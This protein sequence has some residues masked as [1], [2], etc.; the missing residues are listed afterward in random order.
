MS[1]LSNLLSNLCQDVFKLK[2]DDTSEIHKFMEALADSMESFYDQINSFLLLSTEY[3]SSGTYLDMIARG[4]GWDRFYG[5][6]ES[7]YKLRFKAFL[8]MPKNG[9]EY[10]L[11]I[12]Q[13]YTF[14]RPT[15][16]LTSPFNIS[17]GLGCAGLVLADTCFTVGGPPE[18]GSGIGDF[19]VLYAGAIYDDLHTGTHVSLTYLQYILNQIKPAGVVA[20]LNHPC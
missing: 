13:M 4:Y 1:A 10:I 5:E 12:I 2:E 19:G 18:F 7:D 14:D 20:T 17:L 16:T 8:G 11:D 3:L 15:M 9:S 6:S